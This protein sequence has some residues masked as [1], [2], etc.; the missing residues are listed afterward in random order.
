MTG[1][2]QLYHQIWFDIINSKY[3]TA[4]G[5]QIKPSL[6]GRAAFDH[7]GW[8][9]AISSWSTV[10]VGIDELNGEGTGVPTETI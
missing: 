1:I 9:A 4:Q 3:V 7:G 10:N 8:R 6:C 2:K 5:D